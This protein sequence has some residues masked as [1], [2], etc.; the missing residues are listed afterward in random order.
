MQRLDVSTMGDSITEN[1]ASGK[2]KFLS[3]LKQT[4]SLKMAATNVMLQNGYRSFEQRSDELFS[5]V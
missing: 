2:T 3:I 1:V 4:A 5:A